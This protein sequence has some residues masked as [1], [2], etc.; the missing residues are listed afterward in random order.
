MG[1]KK[2]VCMIVQSIYP[3]DTRVRREA[4]ALVKMGIHVD[5]VCLNNDRRMKVENYGHVRVYRI[6]KNFSQDNVFKYIFKSL[7]FFFLALI[8][9]TRL[10]LANDYNI[11]HVHNM[12]DFLVFASIIAKI[13]QIPIILDIHDLTVEL[14]KEKWGKSNL[15][16]IL[17]LITLQEKISCKFADNIITVTDECKNLL[18][19]R[20]VAE[21]KITL[22]LNTPDPKLFSDEYNREFQIITRNAKL[23]YHGTVARRFG[24]HTMIIAM[25]YIKENLPGSEFHMYGIYDIHYKEYLK[26]LTKENGVENNIFFNNRKSHEDIY[27]IIKTADIGIVPY[28]STEYMHLAHSTKLFEYIATCVP[29]VATELRSLKSIFNYGSISYFD[30]NDPLELSKVVIE[31]CLNAE[32]RKMQVF[33]AQNDLSKISWNIMSER[34]FTLINE[35]T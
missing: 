18:I 9:T 21:K 6:S 1:I 27:Q 33:S 19:S 23:I 30:G 15:K 5:I 34:L 7:L 14:Y 11:I 17:P 26:K 20:G 13:R 10:V 28:T 29:V 4:E 24:L 16:L 22:I 25:K 8:K 12:P 32:K 35:L 2:T 3:E 31:L